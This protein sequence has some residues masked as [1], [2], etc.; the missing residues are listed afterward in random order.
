MS[1]PDL[2]GDAP[3]AQIL[4]PVEVGCVEA[5]RHQPDVSGTHDG[6]EH[7]T[8]AALLPLPRNHGLV[9]IDEPLLADLRLNGTAAPAV[10]GFAVGVAF[11][12]VHQQPLALELFH[13]FRTCLINAHACK[14]LCDGQQFSVEIDD[15]FL[16]ES[17]AFG[18]FKVR[19]V[20]P[21]G[22]GHHAR[23][24][25]RIHR[26]V[27]DDRGNHRPV[28]PL[29]L[30]GVTVLE[31]GIALVLRMHDDILVAELGFR[32]HRADLEGSVLEGVEGRLH[33]LAV[34]LVIRDVGV[35]FGIPVDA[36]RP[37]VDQS[38][39]VHAHEGFIDT[40][41]ELGGHRVAVAA[42]VTTR[43]HRHHLV[44][45][46]APRLLNVFCDAPQH[47]FASQ[48][49]AGIGDALLFPDLLENHI[50]GCNRR[51]VGSRN[52][53]R[54]VAH[55][56]MPADEDVFQ[57]KHHRMAHMQLPSRIGWRHGDHKGFSLRC[58][59]GPEEALRL[60]LLGNLGFK[61]LWIVS[62]GQ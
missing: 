11:I 32:A 17:M 41:V 53:K 48:L 51:V 47:L 31:L 27:L 1:P 46:R 18:D 57:R 38:R 24:E 19:V 21:R 55:H 35:Q 23:S 30:E 3:V 45:D 10:E 26:L 6:D 13:D 8:Q 2:A 52:P 28:D 49:G 16:V 37:P 39:L 29:A 34:H 33:L 50:L 20:M 5:V 42:P 60:P 4:H 14:F 62:F 25:F 40:A 15:R 44:A 7:F 56:A 58:D 43:P 12:R 61:D 36:A 9:D 22:D 59:I 54:L